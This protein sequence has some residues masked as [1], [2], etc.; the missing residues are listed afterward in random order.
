MR[1]NILGIKNTIYKVYF[2][3][4]VFFIG[5]TLSVSS[6]ND[7]LKK[8]A[9]NAKNYF[10]EI[11]FEFQKNKIIIPVTIE[12]KTYRFLLDTGAPNIISSELY[13]AIQPKQIET[14]ST[15]DA[16]GKKQNL[17]IVSL[18]SIHIGAVE[19][20]NT[21]ALVYDLNGSDI[22]RC[23]G[24]DGFIGSNLLRHSII[25]IDSEKKLLTLT[26]SRKKLGLKKKDASKMK[27]VGSQSSPYVWITV[28]GKEKGNEHVLIDT[29]MGG[30]YDLSKNN[31]S[32]FKGKNIFNEI[33][34]SD[35]ASSV[36][37]FGEVPINNQ[38]R[39]HLPKLVVNNFEI[40][41]CITHTTKDNNSR[42]G[43]EI[44]DYGIMTIDFKNKRFYFN[45]KSDTVD[46][47]EPA[48]GFTTT[49]KD[50]RVV[51]GYVWDEELRQ[52]LKYGDIVLAINGEQINE[53]SLCSYI[54]KKSVI[55]SLTD[56]VLNIENKEGEVYDVSITKKELSTILSDFNISL[57]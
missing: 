27:L 36:S 40:Q 2:L 26:D 45:P 23:F 41:N 13:K 32:I 42:I 12:G 10:E 7:L 16:N 50:N 53:A 28:K 49:L 21:A 31:Y 44:L 22:F 17:D 6:Q 52:K 20:I 25:Q 55:A 8:G 33:G 39:V 5:F 29:G 56:M 3:I 18:N 46:V 54:I 43:A 57:N 24:I 9:V 51:I 35:G 38:L 37:L 1:D 14:I 30:L 15:R 4:G 19:F 47:I 11:V 48:P 34:Q